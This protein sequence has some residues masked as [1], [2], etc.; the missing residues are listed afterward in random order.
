MRGWSYNAESVRDNLPLQP[1]EARFT[2]HL[3]YSL[4]A[5]FEVLWQREVM[6]SLASALSV[7]V[8]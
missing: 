1:G 8:T 5:L 4:P 6:E 2:E 7:D 3:A